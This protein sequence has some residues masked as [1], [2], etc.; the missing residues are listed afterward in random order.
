MIAKNQ[1]RKEQLSA[2]WQNQILN[3]CR[4]ITTSKYPFAKQSTLDASLQD[5]A[6]MFGKTGIIANFF[7]THLA[8]LVNTQTRPWS[9][10]SNVNAQYQFAPSVLPFFE[11]SHKIQTAL[12]SKNPALASQDIIFTPVFLDPRLSQIKFSIFGKNF[13]YQFGR[14][15]P[16]STT[17]P[18]SNPERNSEIIFVRR[19]NSELAL[20]DNGLFSFFKLIETSEINRK[21][22][23]EVEVTFSKGEHTAIYKL[24]S[25]NLSDPLLLSNLSQFSCIAGL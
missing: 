3:Q 10:K 5:I 25:N 23:N 7:D 17:W 24:T 6:L 22:F 14:P 11:Q 13:N 18:P 16:V 4:T 21:S 15:S 20:R 9:W 1:I 19:D 12:F 8:E 2:L